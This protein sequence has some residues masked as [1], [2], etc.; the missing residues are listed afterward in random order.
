MPRRFALLIVLLV[1]SIIASTQPASGQTQPV[2]DYPVGLDRDAET[3]ALLMVLA[4]QD[5]PIPQP[6]RD[7]ARA[8]FALYT[9]HPAVRS[10]GEL[11]GRVGL[12]GVLQ[13]A[14]LARPSVG[15]V[16]PGDIAWGM[17]GAA[18][19]GDRE[20]GRARLDTYAREMAAFYAE[21]DVG[22]FF[23]AWDSTYAQAADDV[24]ALLPGRD[25][26]DALEAYYGE[27]P[28]SYEV[29]V[30]LLWR[31]GGN[32]GF[33][34]PTDEGRAQV[35]VVAPWLPTEDLAASRGFE[36]P[37]G[38]AEDTMR[39]F[40]QALVLHEFGHPFVTPH[41]AALADRIAG[42]AHLLAPIQAEMTAASYR[43]WWSAVNEHAVRLGEVRI[44]LAMGDSALA[45]TLRAR[46]LARGFAYL[47]ALEPVMGRYE[48]A[49]P[50]GT[51]RYPSFAA[52]APEFVEALSYL[53]PSDAYR[54]IGLGPPRTV[55]FRV[56]A[57]VP[58]G[59]T[60]F[61]TGDAA[62]LGAWDARGVHLRREGDVWT[63][64]VEMHEGQSARFGVTRGAWGQEAADA[65][66][67]PTPATA[68]TVG[69]DTTLSVRVVRW[70]DE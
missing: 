8:T 56:T 21:A 22:A 38:M 61:V 43:G 51:G 66:G 48:R 50:Q 20:Q 65:D 3:G 53:R 7:E 42:T 4:G 69:A 32:G 27:Q 52:F 24:A 33:S 68:F 37:P 25:A 17:A 64:A 45:D 14:L 30:S 13:I 18:G 57:S 31:G 54:A 23:D 58:P 63:G 62:A 19:G 9:D 34:R 11:M 40:V 44:A 67:E 10:T 47:P 1:T 29:A 46:H 35:Y 59:D 39:G 41:L 12:D 70:K 28:A 16:R 49:G 2:T 5:S 36:I 26:L 60:V 15:G 6:L 55:R